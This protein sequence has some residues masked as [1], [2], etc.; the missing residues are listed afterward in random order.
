LW[1]HI[2][3]GAAAAAAAVAVLS[4]RA[5][6]TRMCDERANE[7]AQTAQT[8]NWIKQSEYAGDAGEISVSR[9]ESSV[10]RLAKNRDRNRDKRNVH[11]LGND[12]FH[13]S[14]LVYSWG[15]LD[16]IKLIYIEIKKLHADLFSRS[17]EC[18][19]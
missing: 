8:R 1:P 14:H 11:W 9:R 5:L 4:T 19:V 17:I 13:G 10:D 6:A 15:G 3:R 16:Y 12:P 2:D 7:R 18:F